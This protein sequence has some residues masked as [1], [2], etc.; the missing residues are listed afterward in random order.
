MHDWKILFLRGKPLYDDEVLH[1]ETSMI[2]YSSSTSD[3][4]KDSSEILEDADLKEYLVSIG[5]A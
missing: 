3:N 4:R 1:E 2:D 5:H